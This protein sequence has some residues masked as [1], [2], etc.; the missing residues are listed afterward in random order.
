MHTVFTYLLTQTHT[1]T[2]CNVH[3]QKEMKEIT[4][5]YFSPKT[6]KTEN[7]KRFYLD[8]TVFFIPELR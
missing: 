8:A 6:K 2:K 1:Y 3:D 4:K 7:F 5:I